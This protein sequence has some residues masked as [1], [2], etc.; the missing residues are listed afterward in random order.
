MR[1]NNV[2]H[3]RPLQP[4]PVIT[5]VLVAVHFVSVLTLELKHRELMPNLGRAVV[6][7][8]APLEARNGSGRHEGEETK[9]ERRGNRGSR[10]IEARN[11]MMG[12]REHAPQLDMCCRYMCESG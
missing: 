7:S 9:H 11:G 6:L 5:R 1:Q 4:L 3:P 8:L 10:G 2:M 12:V